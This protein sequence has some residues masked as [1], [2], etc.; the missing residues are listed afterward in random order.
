MSINPCENL[1]AQLPQN[2]RDHIGYFVVI[3]LI[4]ECASKPLK[5]HKPF[6]HMQSSEPSYDFYIE[7]LSK[8]DQ[9]FVID[10]TEVFNLIKQGYDYNGLHLNNDKSHYKLTKIKQINKYPY[11]DITLILTC[12]EIFLGGYNQFNLPNNPIC[13]FKKKPTLPTINSLLNVNQFK[14]ADTFEFID[15]FPY[16]H[17]I[18]IRLLNNENQTSNNVIVI[19]LPGSIQATPFLE[20]CFYRTAVCKR[21]LIE[22]GQ[23]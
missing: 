7:N 6:L 14:H 17:A 3:D 19:P 12:Y 9:R 22:G 1:F 8:C 4:K 20:D 10:E 5:H 13:V 21:L 2:V 18:A 11:A 15:Y 16:A 23:E